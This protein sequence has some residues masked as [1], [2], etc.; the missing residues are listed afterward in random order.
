MYG[1]ARAD[2]FER[3]RR[4]N[5][6]AT[7]AVTLLLGVL[8]VPARNAHYVAFSV[9]DYEG[10]YNSAW[11][12]AMFAM[13]ATFTLSLFGFYTI[14]S[15]LALDRQTR[16]GEIVASTSV[17]KFEYVLGKTLSNC[18]IL[19]SMLAVLFV[20][21]IFMQLVRGEDRSIQLFAIAYPFVAIAL[22]VVAIVSA[23]A[24]LFETIP[25]LRGGFGNVI[26]FFAWLFGLSALGNEKNAGLPGLSDPL[27]LKIMGNEI[28]AGIARV[29]PRAAAKPLSVILIGG[30]DRSHIFTWHG[31]APSLGDLAARAWWIGI[32][33]AVVALAALCFDRFAAPA[34]AA[35][36]RPPHP[37]VARW[38]AAMERLS[39]PLFDRIFGSDFGSLV[40]AELRLMLRGLS[41]WWYAVAAGLWIAT[42]FSPAKAQPILLGLL[43]L[44]PM[45]VWSPMG[46]R[47]TVD[48]TSHLVFSCVHPLRRQFLALW[49][50]G[51]ALALSLGGGALLHAFATHDLASLAGVLAGAFFIPSLALACGAAFG[52]SRVFEIVYLVLWYAGPMNRGGFDYTS[53]ASAP[54]TALLA[55]AFVAAAFAMRRV[56]LQHA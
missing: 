31:F 44:W 27:G 40:L 28:A 49:V 32:A 46:T 48:E 29:D 43:W 50:A 19:A 42:L 39:D 8:F 36:A 34:R 9:D 5:Y 26:Y 13:L 25:F 16:C 7:I 4:Y 38:Q 23:L 2:F 30:D 20:V 33:L 15:G 3:A 1:I 47:E 52:T 55:L 37:A 12:G 41:I 56:R 18:A 51:V 22:P 11:I 14:K 53:S 45:L 6:L 24:V 17:G 10:I 54:V 21:A 35:G